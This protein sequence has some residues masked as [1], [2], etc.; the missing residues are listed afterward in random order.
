MP[1]PSANIAVAILFLLLFSTAFAQQ[2]A[3]I[4]VERKIEG[5]VKPGEIIEVKLS[6][7]FRETA[8]SGIILTEFPPQGWEIT[9]ALPQGT[10]F[11]DK[12]SWL[13]YGNKVK[14][15][16]ITYQLKA[17]QDFNKAVQ[18]SGAWQTL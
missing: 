12:Y 18:L 2:L 5:T 10:K 4:S 1:K 3:P 13:L 11:K 9:G 17:P 15:S 8:P 16:T 7:K 6:L 14:D